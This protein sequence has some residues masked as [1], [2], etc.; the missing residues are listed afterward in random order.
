VTDAGDSKDIDMVRWYA[1]RTQPAQERR[2]EFQ[3]RQQGYVTFLPLLKKSVR[4]ARK[5]RQVRAALF[6]GYLFVQLDLDRDRWRSV[7][8]TYGVS[9]LIMGGDQPMPVPVGVVESFINLTQ[10][11]GLVDFTPNLKLG[12]EVVLVSGGL[13]GMIGRLKRCDGKG[14]VEVLLQIMGQEVCVKSNTRSLMPA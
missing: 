3:L 12:A 11:D 10:A 7:N 6:P 4:H 13:S 8:S 2:A 14:R 5:L 9:G 1:V